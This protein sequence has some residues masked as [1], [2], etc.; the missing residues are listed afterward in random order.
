MSMHSFFRFPMRFCTHS[1]RFNAIAASFSLAAVL[2]LFC[3]ST[4]EV[5]D[6]AES[7]KT[8]EV[9]EEVLTQESTE[10]RV[11][12]RCN[13]V[14]LLP[15]KCKGANFRLT[16]RWRSWSEQGNF[17]GLGRPLTI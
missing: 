1:V 13:L 8:V 6:A 9:E 3:F 14:R 15:G 7:E 11:L 10:S 16:Q 5:K 4:V 12:R 2:G 17:N